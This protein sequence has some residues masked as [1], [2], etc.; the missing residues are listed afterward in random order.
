[1]D[2]IVCVDYVR[3][4]YFYS[5]DTSYGTSHKIP[6]K[7]I[8]TCIVY[9]HCA[10]NTCITIYKIFAGLNLHERLQNRIFTYELGIVQLKYRYQN[11]IF[12]KG[13]FLIKFA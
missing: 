1:M 7:C 9:I 11:I 5:T 4:T 3:P 8:C 13:N 6:S 2:V 12:M 10:H